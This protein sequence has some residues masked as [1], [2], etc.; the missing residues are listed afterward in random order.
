LPDRP[1]QVKE[2]HKSLA[3]GTCPTRSLRSGKTITWG[4]RCSV[5]RGEWEHKP[6]GAVGNAPYAS[7][8]YANAA[9]KALPECKGGNTKHQKK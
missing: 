3:K 1:A 6:I 7:E 5:K 8:E 2:K 4:D 9:I